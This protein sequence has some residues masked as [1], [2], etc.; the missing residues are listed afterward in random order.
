MRLLLN[1]VRSMRNIS[2]RELEIMTGISKS[3]LC[4]Y[5]AVGN[6]NADIEK[7]ERIAKALG[8]RINDLFDSE[9]K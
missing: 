3:T 4:R 6:V 5:E 8:V 1:E 9:Y 2:L 7:L